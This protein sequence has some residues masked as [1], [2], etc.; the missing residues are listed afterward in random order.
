[1]NRS[2][3]DGTRAARRVLFFL[4]LLCMPAVAPANSIVVG[5]HDL[6]PGQA[7]Q[8]VTLFMTGT[9]AYVASDLYMLINNG[10]PGA[11][12]ITHV[13]DTTIAAIPTA[14]FVGS[15]WEG[16]SGGV[17]VTPP[18]GTTSAGTGLSTGAAFFTPGIVPST[19]SGI[20]V[21]LT[22]DTTGVLPGVYSFSLTDNPSYSPT[23]VTA[24]LD[25]ETF[26][27]IFI[28]LTIVNGT[29]TV[30][31]EPSSVMLGLFA[32]FGLAVVAIRSR[33]RRAA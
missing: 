20:Y 26:M 24:G 32:M 16:G 31:P 3:I 18:D 30:V 29:L 19:S 2:S 9:D 7:G 12:V 15:I 33:S 1:M 13:F 6:V 23:T 21:R 5:N 27:P 22:F 4:G 11:P 17:V 28:P 14:N 8:V 10:S 25:P